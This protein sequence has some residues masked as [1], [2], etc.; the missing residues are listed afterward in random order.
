MAYPDGTTTARVYYSVDLGANPQSATSYVAYV[1]RSSVSTAA[2]G[3]TT[4]YPGVTETVFYYSFLGGSAFELAGSL[5]GTTIGLDAAL[6]WYLEFPFVPLDAS[7]TTPVPIDPEN[8]GV[9]SPV[10]VSALAYDVAGFGVGHYVGGTYKPLGYIGSSA[11]YPAS[12]N[13]VLTPLVLKP[14]G[15]FWTNFNKSQEIIQ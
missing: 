8:P 2:G 13:V 9:H 14:P 5:S 10:L 7:G 1:A 4:E 6:G 3:P 11:T 12:E 15:A